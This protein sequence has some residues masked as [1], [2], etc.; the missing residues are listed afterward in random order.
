MAA[1]VAAVCVAEK[2]HV[3]ME[4][5]ARQ[6]AGHSSA[7]PKSSSIGTLARAVRIIEENPFPAHLSAAAR[8]FDALIP[9]MPAALAYL[10]SNTWLFGPLLKRLL[11][12]TPATNAMVRT[13]TAVT[14]AR[15]GYKSNV[16]PPLAT[17]VV[18]HRIHPD[19]SVSFVQKRYDELLR[20]LPVT[21]RAMQTLEPA[22]VSSTSSP[23]FSALAASSRAVFAGP[24]AVA[25]A[26]M[27]GN[28]DTRWYWNLAED[29]YR[30]NPTELGMHE[31]GMF[32]GRDERIAVDNLARMCAFYAG[33]VARTAG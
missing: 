10:F 7:P 6:P 9:D 15:A 27:V 31:V 17:A 21:T 16:L 5:V 25:P 30:H 8:L 13:T 2:G 11:G 29:I 33:V 28:T 22:P 12:L 24:L 1:R 23:A 18:N 3:N 19:E 14:I 26:L 32:H 20:G 4:I